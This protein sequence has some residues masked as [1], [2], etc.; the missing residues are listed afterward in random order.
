MTLKPRR[1][2]AY[3]LRLWMAGNK[4]TPTWRAS[5]ES[6]HTGERWGFTDLEALAAFLREQT[7]KL[8]SME[9]DKGEEEKTS[10]GPATGAF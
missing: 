5:L 7:E 8:S 2:L 6:P 10:D 3:M 1:Y 4:D 9:K